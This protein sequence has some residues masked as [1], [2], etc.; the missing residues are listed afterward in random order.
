MTLA[1]PGPRTGISGIEKSRQH[2][3][4][5]VS[6]EQYLFMGFGSF[7]FIGLFSVA[8]VG[9]SPGIISLL[10]ASLS[11]TLGAWISCESTRSCTICT[12]SWTI[13][14]CRVFC[15]LLFESVTFEL[16]AEI[17]GASGTEK[18]GNF[19]KIYINLQW[20]FFDNENAPSN[21]STL[22]DATK[23]INVLINSISRI[24]G[25]FI[26]ISLHQNIEVNQSHE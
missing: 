25:I 19:S 9:F 7:S 23:A 20:I 22:L 26:F 24:I 4:D 14:S 13:T 12:E 15:L 16:A 10:I 8:M 5:A 11:P 2:S 18:T 1:H 17:T 21:L 6:H 3:H